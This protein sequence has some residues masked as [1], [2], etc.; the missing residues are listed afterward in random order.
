MAMSSTR[1]CQK[2][3]SRPERMSAKS[4]ENSTLCVCVC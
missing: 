4:S 2:M 3:D 1:L